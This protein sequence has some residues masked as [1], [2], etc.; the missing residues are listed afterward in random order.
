MLFL[1]AAGAV[2]LLALPRDRAELVRAVSLVVALVAFAASLPL[3]FAYTGAEGMAFT[4]DIEW[5]ASP[6]IR[7]HIGVDGISLFL[8]LQ[9]GR[10]HV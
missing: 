6:A 9:I 10:A 3:A 8:V 7:Y 2:L 1:P 4:T 5:I